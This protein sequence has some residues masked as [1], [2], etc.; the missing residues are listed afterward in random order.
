MK[1]RIA[2]LTGALVLGAAAG[3]ALGKP[4]KRF[5]FRGRSVIITGGSRGLGLELARQLAA[6]RARLTIIARDQMVLRRA[7]KELTAMGAEVLTIACDVRQ[8]KEVVEAVART[9]TA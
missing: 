5:S 6:Q 7:E 4:R 2:F 9:V 3:I 8:Q 1:N